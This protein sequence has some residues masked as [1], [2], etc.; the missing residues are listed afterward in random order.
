MPEATSNSVVN[1]GDIAKPADT[2]IKKISA[3]VGG[4]FAP[5]QI[6]RLAEAEAAA[7]IIKSAAEIEVADLQRRAVRRFVEEET[8]FQKN[9]EDITAKALPQLN[10]SSDPSRVDDDWISNFFDKSRIISNCEMQELWSRILAGEANSPG[11]YSKRTVNFLSSIDKNE[12][13]RFANLLG[14]GWTVAELTPLVFDV[15]ADIYTTHGTNFT[16]LVNLESIG[17]IQF[18]H[19]AGFTMRR[20]PKNFSVS[21]FDRRLNLEMKGE[22]DNTIETGNVLLTKV[23]QELATVCKGQPVDGFIEYVM[24]RWKE[25]SPV[26]VPKFNAS[27]A[28][29]SQLGL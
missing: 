20:L 1:L 16:S 15:Q 12:A 6:K 22:K 28:S 13:Q 8:Q 25:Y 29:L 19:L 4:L 21:Y 5:Y 18:D 7:A 11:S 17:L 27:T 9:M 14:F 10:D 24:E 23:G 2:L 26:L 3:A